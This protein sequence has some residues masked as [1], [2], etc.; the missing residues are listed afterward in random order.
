[1][2]WVFI[3]MCTNIVVCNYSSMPTST[4]VLLNPIRN[5]KLLLR[6]LND[7]TF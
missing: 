6:I 5:T 3:Y 1:M 7:Y 2:A 4:L